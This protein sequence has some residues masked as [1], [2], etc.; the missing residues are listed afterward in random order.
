[1]FIVSSS[2]L[3]TKCFGV[4]IHAKTPNCAILFIHVHLALSPLK[5]DRKGRKKHLSKNLITTSNALWP[6][7][8][9]EHPAISFWGNRYHYTVSGMESSMVYKYFVSATQ[10]STKT[11]KLGLPTGWSTEWPGNEAREVA[12]VVWEH[13]YEWFGNKT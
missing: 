2:C 6:G 5:A 3:E 10:C 9:G 12:G 4:L 1:M 11:L 8:E 7:R 13:G